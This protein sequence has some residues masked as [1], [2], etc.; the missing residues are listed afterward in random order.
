M[1]AN[2]T[3]ERQHNELRSPYTLGYSGIYASVSRSASK[4]PYFASLDAEASSNYRNMSLFGHTHIW[5]VVSTDYTAPHQDIRDI[6]SSNINLI[7]ATMQGV[8]HIY[9]KCSLCGKIR[10]Q[11]VYGKFVSVNPEE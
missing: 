10:E 1:I 9:Q 2:G 11:N 7:K 5:K 8:T 4:D 3:Y 6:R